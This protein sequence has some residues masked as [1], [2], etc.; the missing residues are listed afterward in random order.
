VTRETHPAS[1]SVPDDKSLGDRCRRRAGGHRPAH[2]D[3]AA[4]G[5]AGTGRPIYAPPP[6][7]ACRTGPPGRLT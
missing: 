7:P 3:I 5:R 4:G 1:F 2:R 6:V